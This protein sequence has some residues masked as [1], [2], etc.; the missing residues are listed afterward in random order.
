MD[1][2]RDHVI[3]KQQGY[4]PLSA[5]LA[6]GGAIFLAFSHWYAYSIGGDHREN[7][8]IAKAVEARNDAAKNANDASANLEKGNAKARVVYRTITR[9]VDRI[10]DRPIYRN[11]CFDDDGLREVNA[12]LAGTSTGKPDGTVPGSDKAGGWFRGLRPPKAD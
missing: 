10:V 8:L 12:A 7:A 11:V 1:E 3:Y 2:H 6:I 4:L 9:T 5:Y